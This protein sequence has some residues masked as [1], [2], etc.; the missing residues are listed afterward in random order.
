[1]GLGTL[2]ELKMQSRGA[3]GRSHT[4]FLT[5]PILPF[6]RNTSLAG[7]DDDTVDWLQRTHSASDKIGPN[8][9][10][11]IVLREQDFSAPLLSSLQLLSPPLSSPVASASAT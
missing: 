6:K 9:E 7:L 5:S 1:M 10:E 8:E 11:C 4:S 3:N 2:G